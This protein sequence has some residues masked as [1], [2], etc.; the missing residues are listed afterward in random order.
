MADIK[1]TNDLISVIVTTYNRPDALQLVLD[2]CFAQTDRNFEIVIAD[3]GSG[4][5]TRELIERIAQRA[6]VPVTHV[7][8]PDEGFRAAASRNKGIA[9]ARGKYLIFLD[10]DCVPQRDFI[11]RHRALAAPRTVVTGSRVLLGQKLTKAALARRLPIF[12]LSTWFW[13]RQRATG[14]INKV[15]PLLTRLP[16]IS[17]RRV[18]GFVWRGIKTCNL[19]AWRSDIEAIN[20]FD[21]TFTG[22]GHEDADLVVRLHNSG[23]ARKNGFC[24]TEVLHLWHAHEARDREKQNQERVIARL[25]RGTTRAERGLHE[26]EHAVEE[27]QHADV[28]DTPSLLEQ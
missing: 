18:N 21:E 25:A 22:W 5:S 24:A 6:A 23:V 7:W 19:A 17:R 15:L 13:L 9:R 20:G 16:D 2:G 27:N 26:P 14:Q 12:E 10:G 4:M 3:D 1:K 8:Q 11:A 28:I